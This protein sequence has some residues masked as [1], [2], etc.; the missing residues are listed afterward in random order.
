MVVFLNINIEHT[1]QCWVSSRPDKHSV[2]FQYQVCESGDTA[3]ERGLPDHRRIKWNWRSPIRGQ[4]ICAQ[5]KLL[6]FIHHKRYGHERCFDIY[7]SPIQIIIAQTKVGIVG[8]RNS[9]CY[10]GLFT[11]H[12]FSKCNYKPTEMASRFESATSSVPA[13][14]LVIS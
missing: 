8:C 10:T 7:F 5:E 11:P 1:K 3:L 6:R 4:S 12:F 14:L 13:F 9:C 2:E